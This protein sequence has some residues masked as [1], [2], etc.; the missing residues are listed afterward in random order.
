VRCEQWAWRFVKCWPR[1]HP[2]GW[3]GIEPCLLSQ[4]RKRYGMGFRFER[5]S[6]GAH[7]HASE[8][9]VPCEQGEIHPVKVGW[10]A[11]SGVPGKRRSRLLRAAGEEATGVFGAGLPQKL[12]QSDELVVWFPDRCF[13]AVASV[14]RA[15]KRR[16]D[17]C[18]DV[19]C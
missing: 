18:P 8:V 2:A 15:R 12:R 4:C 7:A 6:P 13:D 16:R 11:W 19:E 1:V 14:M 5:L 17:W 3:L 10:W 9:R